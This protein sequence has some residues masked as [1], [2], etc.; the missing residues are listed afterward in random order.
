VHDI[1]FLV[2]RLLTLTEPTCLFL[3][4]QAF[5]QLWL[6]FILLQLEIYFRLELP[7]PDVLGM[8][9]LNQPTFI[10]VKLSLHPYN[11]DIVQELKIEPYLI[12]DLQT[13]SLWIGQLKGLVLVGGTKLVI[14]KHDIALE[15]VRQV[16]VLL[17]G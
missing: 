13:V 12:T 3:R 7:N 5:S 8:V 11:F 2:D 10:L 1:V 17:V 6:G 9:E 16:S 4:K 15:L 14:V